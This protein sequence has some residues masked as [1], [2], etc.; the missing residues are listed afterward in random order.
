MVLGKILWFGGRTSKGR[1]NDFGFLQFNNLN[2]IEE[3]YVHRQDISGELQNIC[4]ND[5]DKG[6]GIWVE[7]EIKGYERGTKAVNV[8]LYQKIGIVISKNTFLEICQVWC[9]SGSKYSLSNVGFVNISDII[10]FGIQENEKNTKTALSSSKIN[11]Q[12]VEIDLVK[13]FI[14]NLDYSLAKPLIRFYMSVSS[15]GEKI[16]FVLQKIEGLSIINTQDFL[17]LIFSDYNDLL[18]KSSQLRELIKINN[19]S[20]YVSLIKNCLNS[21]DK[22]TKEQLWS[23]LS[24]A[25]YNHLDYQSFTLKPLLDIY[26]DRVNQEEVTRFLQQN[27]NLIEDIHIPNFL[28]IIFNSRKDVF[29]SFQEN[30]EVLK[31]YNIN[32]YATL[33]ENILD[34]NDELLR[35]KIWQELIQYL[36]NCSENNCDYLWGHISYLEKNLEY[37][38][39]LWD[40]SPSSYKQTVIKERYSKF[41]ALV[42]EFKSS[43]YVGVNHISMSYKELYDFD[44]NDKRLA[45]LWG[46]NTE[47]NFER[48]KMLSARGAEKL[49]KRFYQNI[50]N[51]VEDIAIDQ[52]SGK[53]QIWRQADICINL[54]NSQRLIDVKNAR[55][56]VNSNV[57]SE[58]CIPKFK[59]NRNQ[60]VVIAAVLSPYLQLQYMNKE[61]AFFSVSNPQYLGELTCSQLQSLIQSFSDG[62]VSL[63]MTRG[64]DPKSYLAPWLFDYNIQFYQ[65]QIKI[66]NKLRSL[67]DD[68]IPSYDDLITLGI[69]S[70]YSYIPLYIFTNK[71]IPKTWQQTLSAWEINFI[72]LLYRQND[73]VLKLPHLYMSILKHFLLMLFGNNENYSPIKIINLLGSDSHPLKLYDPLGIIKDFCK[74]L[75]TLWNNR[76][77]ANLTRFRI[78]KFSGQGLLEGKISTSHHSYTTILAYCGGWVEQK[79][80]CGFVPLVIGREKNCPTCG[81]LICPKDD[82]GYCSSNCE[83]YQQRQKQRR[84]Y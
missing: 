63:D 50:G 7:F 37:Q 16:D 40:I 28:D 53:S 19:I 72:K 31:R 67:Q 68:E 29:I 8:S 74:T 26:F 54:E 64:F 73:S 34:G 38:N 1:V 81:K 66:A 82:C 30:R 22:L 17:N 10:K 70:V 24:E 71:S 36:T 51:N 12:V 13:R 39:Y 15:T 57:Y 55:Q 2:S 27:I 52:I 20:H 44:D 58:F 49:V 3:I 59:E 75:E 25:V 61:G 69:T 78:F 83:A 56:S 14:D 65:E 41:F 21:D 32:L 9:E 76:L 5:R 18:F 84:R 42:H 77:Q 35:Q 4:E 60:D 79:G 33:I 45:Q 43:E 62:V 23:E 48:A 46:N 6:K 11:L 80:K 47:N